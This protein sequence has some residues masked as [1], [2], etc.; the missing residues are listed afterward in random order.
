VLQPPGTMPVQAPQQPPENV[1]RMSNAGP[2]RRLPRRPI[3]LSTSP[4]QQ[5]TQRI[6]APAVLLALHGCATARPGEDGFVGH[7]EDP[8]GLASGR[9]GQANLR[10][11][12][13]CPLAARSATDTGCSPVA[14]AT[15]SA[16][17]SR[18]D[19]FFLMTLPNP[20]FDSFRYKSCAMSPPRAGYAPL[21]KDP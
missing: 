10:G 8:S 12:G 7:T 16:V 18:F 13:N 17:P 1:T 11:P 3:G 14:S 4:R 2:L 5:S 6:V 15:S 21:G 20:G 19:A 9:Q